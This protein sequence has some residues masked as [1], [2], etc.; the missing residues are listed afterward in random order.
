MRNALFIDT[1]AFLAL[2]D[3]SDDYH[4][5]AITFRDNVIQ[6]G[7]YNIITTSYVLDETLTLIRMRIGIKPSIDFCKRIRSSQIITIYSVTEKIEQKALDLFE[8]FDDKMFSFTDCVS[9]VVMREMGI[10]EAFG[11]DRHFEQMQFVRRP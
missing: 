8:K 3:K 6:R 9:F 10:T 7:I 2:E 4:P 11:F 1:G 5:E